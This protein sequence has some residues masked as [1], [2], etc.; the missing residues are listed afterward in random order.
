MNKRNSSRTLPSVNSL[1][2]ALLL[3]V[4]ASASLAQQGNSALGRLSGGDAR[5][6]PLP[7]TEAFPFYVSQT[8]P[9]E[10]RITWNPASGHYLYRHAFGFSL[11]RT[12]T[13][14]ARPLDF[15]L[16]PGIPRSDQ[17]FGDIEAYYDDVSVTLSLPEA[18]PDSAALII[19]YQG[20]ADWG[21]C[22]PP[23]RQAYPLA[24]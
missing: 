17:F 20:C 14:D 16:P 11:Q 8:A 5:P 2:A 13:S 24:P 3:C 18:T 6:R 23:Q 12:A 19:E 9:G 7:L 4:A 22:Y 21:F 1:L 15:S 10:Y